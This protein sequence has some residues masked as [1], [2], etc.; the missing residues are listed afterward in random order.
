MKVTRANLE[1]SGYKYYEAPEYK[2]SSALYQKKIANDNGVCY[3]I[4]IYEYDL[5]SIRNAPYDLA[6]QTDMQFRRDDNYFNVSF[7]C[8]DIEDAEKYAEEFFVKMNFEMY[9]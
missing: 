6:Y 3:F 5:S 1:L 9:E 7:S 8:Q 4:N 2:D